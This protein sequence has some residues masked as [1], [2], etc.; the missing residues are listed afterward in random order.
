MLNDL[1]TS[2][3]SISPEQLDALFSGTP[4]AFTPQLDG[5]DPKPSQAVVKPDEKP[6][7]IPQPD[8]IPMIESIDSL[9]GEEYNPDAPEVTPPEE[10][11]DTPK[12]EEKKDEKP[13]EKK[14]DKPEEP[15][16]ADVKAI[17]TVLKNTVEFLVK[18]GVFK[19]FEGREELDIDEETYA[20][21]VEQQ[22]DAIVD[23]RFSEKKKATGDYGQ[24]ILDYIENGGDPDQVIDIFKERKALEQVT[25]DSPESHKEI[26]TKWYKEQHGWRDDR[27]KKTIDALAAESDEAL[28]TEAEEIKSK[29]DD[30]YNKQIEE[31]TTRQAE[32]KKQYDIQ[33]EE[34]KK[35]FETN[36]NKAITDT[37]YDDK[38][39]KFLKDSLFR[40]K[41]LE[42]GRKVNE[43]YIKFAEWQADPK[44]YVEL[45]E[46]IMDKD[47]YLKKE[48]T[49]IQ[50]KVTEKTFNFVK[51]NAALDKN[52]G[53]KHAEREESSNAKGTDFSVVFKRK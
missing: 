6:L 4:D 1:N 44:K 29:Y 32:A 41:K 40:F 5:T 42:D 7:V 10:K 16:E 45:L 38:R 3:A 35:Q 27:I 39:Q 48:E 33:Q 2:V 49:K 34:L 51:G 12:P 15:V 26:I 53:S 24:V 52:K 9:L 36:I 20:S 22:L 18:K 28:Q 46:F 14:D 21:L 8:N 31:V 13:E 17:N 25:L 11:K 50:N 43:F 23:E 37:G 47:G 19:D 30:L